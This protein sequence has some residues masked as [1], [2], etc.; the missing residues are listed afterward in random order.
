MFYKVVDLVTIQFQAD[1]AHAIIYLTDKRLGAFYPPVGARV[2]AAVVA[3]DALVVGQRP[4]VRA[5][6]LPPPRVRDINKSVALFIPV[7]PCV[8]LS[9]CQGLQM[10]DAQ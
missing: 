5:M 3:G 4:A 9:L 7:S 6:S 1:L 2:H 10:R 8:Q